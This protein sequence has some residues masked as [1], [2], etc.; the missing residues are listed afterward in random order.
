MLPSVVILLMWI[1]DLESEVV[2]LNIETKA[3]VEIMKAKSDTAFA[4]LSK[5]EKMTAQLEGFEKYIRGY[6]QAISD[7][8]AKPM[9]IRIEAAELPAFLTTNQSDDAARPVV[10]KEAEDKSLRD[11]VSTLIADWME[12]DAEKKAKAQ[13]E[14]LRKEVEQLQKEV[15]KATQQQQQSPIIAPENIKPLDGDQLQRYINSKTREHASKK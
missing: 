11:K 6:T 9:T 3:S 1:W 13:A 10:N 12:T 4:E 14:K 2:R 5:Y 7:G 8:N 15:N